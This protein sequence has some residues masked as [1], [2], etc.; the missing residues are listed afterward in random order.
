MQYESR[1]WGDGEVLVMKGGKNCTTLWMWL[2]PLNGMLGDGWDGKVYVVYIFP[3][4]LYLWHFNAMNLLFIHIVLNFEWLKRQWQVNATYD[5]GWEWAR[6]V[7]RFIRKLLGHMKKKL[8]ID[9]KL[10][11]NVEFLELENHT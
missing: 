3:Q 6:D 8:K 10:Y 5:P 11:I 4:C 2:I 7:R 9:C 1:V